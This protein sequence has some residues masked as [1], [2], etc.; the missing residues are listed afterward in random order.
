MLNDKLDDSQYATMQ[1]PMTKP[2]LTTGDSHLEELVVVKLLLAP[3]TALVHHACAGV[4][5]TAGPPHRPRRA[6]RGIVER[7]LLTL[8]GG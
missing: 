5:A 1:R 4:F 7:G 8:L 2:R 6:A 3:H